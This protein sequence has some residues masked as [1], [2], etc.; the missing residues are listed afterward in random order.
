MANKRRLKKKI[1]DAGS[2]LFAEC[3]AAYLV[4][5]EDDFQQIDDILSN[6]LKTHNDYIKRVSYPEPGMKRK[7]YYGTLWK[8]FTRQ[9][10]EISDNIKALV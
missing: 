6:I 2:E 9:A 5:Q 8:N 1:N 7:T 10:N 4:V 3:I